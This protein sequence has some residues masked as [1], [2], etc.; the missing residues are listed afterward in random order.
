MNRRQFIAG[1]T[2]A[3]LS[4]SLSAKHHTSSTNKPIPVIFDTDI[5]DDI[6][7][8]WALFQ[9]LRSPELDIKLIATDSGNCTYRTRLL[10][11]L[12]DYS[13]YTHLPIAIGRQRG[14][15]PNA[16]S[17][18]LGQYQL[19]E[20]P[21]TVHPD[22]VDAIIQTI[23]ASPDPVTLICVGP[24]PNIA[25]ALKQDPSIAQ[26][27]KFIGMHGSI[28]VGYNRSPQIDAEW[29][30]K[31]APQALQTVL[32]APWDCTLTP[33]DTC[34]DVLLTGEQYRQVRRSHD[35]LA[36]DLMANFDHWIRDVKWLDYPLNPEKQS[37]ILFDTVAVHLAHST[38]WLKMET[39]PIR[40]TDDGY[41]R[42][43]PQKGHPTHCAM[44]WTNRQAFQQDL[45][46]RITNS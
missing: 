32:A 33:L 19:N 30:V 1:S 4:T 20:Y 10:A 24:V 44:Q 28:R 14:D 5:G 21:G 15:E 46:N 27:A 41:T 17:G 2:S 36:K 40:V 34:A 6:D 18:W 42:I 26:N 9:L 38:Q 22:A 43:D 35:P 23:H 31:Q 3:I 37:S 39:L 16:Q 12:L 45:A 7:D 11:K 13:G 25:A 29:N 8:T